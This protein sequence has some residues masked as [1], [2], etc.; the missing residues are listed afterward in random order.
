MV[1]AE[2]RVDS[3]RGC[4]LDLCSSFLAHGDSDL[5]AAVI[6]KKNLL[7]LALSNLHLESPQ[8]MAEVTRSAVY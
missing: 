5:T 3:T 8:S 1:A 7:P 4:F 2:S 6:E